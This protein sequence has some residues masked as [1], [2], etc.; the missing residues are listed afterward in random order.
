MAPRQ[1]AKPPTNED[2]AAGDELLEGEVLEEAE[3]EEVRHLPAVRAAEALVARGE[4][5]VEEIVGQKDK[6][7]QIMQSVMKKDVHY[8]V[9]PGTQKPTLLKPG[10]EAINVAL[11]LAPHYESDKTFH[12]GGHLTVSVVCSLRH[13]PTD[14][15]VATGE[16]LC[17]SYEKKYAVRK[18]QRKCPECGEPQIRKSKFP[19]KD[20]P[21]GTAPGWYCW[22]K[23]G[24]CGAEFAADDQRIAGQEEEGTMPNPDL[25]DTWN[26]V[27]KMADKRALIAAVLNGTAASDVF[28]QDVEDKVGGGGASGAPDVEETKTEQQTDRRVDRQPYPV[29]NSWA[30]IEKAVRAC[31]N[32]E[33][34]WALFQ[35]FIRA[36]SYHL[37][38]EPDSTALTAEQKQVMGQK[39]AGAAVWLQENAE[40]DG[41]FMYFTETWQRQAWAAVLDGAPRLEIPDYQPP[42]DAAAAEAAPELEPEEERDRATE[43]ADDA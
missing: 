18:A 2:E 40:Y 35:A 33:E 41:P 20:A 8:G 25:P 43:G 10:A 12:E 27:L 31:D 21:R 29:P 39:A 16:G 6:I 7:V 5:S 30:D 32:S 15:V 36:C 19:P 13:I 34:A 26:T 24:G 22:K 3:V 38:G 42:L 11:R 1:G 28:T 17:S 14:L 37:Y 23:E 9:I 4:L